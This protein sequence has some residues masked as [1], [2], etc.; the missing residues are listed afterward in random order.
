MRAK[1]ILAT[2][3][4][5]SCLL[6][7]LMVVC[8]TA[9]EEKSVESDMPDASLE[10]TKN[11][12]TEELS[13]EIEFTVI[14][15]IKNLV[16]YFENAALIFENVCVDYQ[17]TFNNNN[18]IDDYT[19]SELIE[20]QFTNYFKTLKIG[21]ESMRNAGCEVISVYNTMVRCGFSDISLKNLIALFENQGALIAQDFVKGKLGSN[22]FAIS[23]VFDEVEIA[24]EK[25]DCVPNI[26]QPGKYVISY[27]LSSD[28]DSAL[29]TVSVEIFNSKALN[30]ANGDWDSILN[31]KFITGYKIIEN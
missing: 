26:D 3:R 1:Y 15:D 10:S 25:L 9:C 31:G 20:S 17:L 28:F 13:L 24:Y 4:I 21:D 11:H 8:F 27:W 16:K 12:S 29:H 14:D 22:P 30:V 18:N 6:A 5:V 23:R 19:A 2:K 7:L